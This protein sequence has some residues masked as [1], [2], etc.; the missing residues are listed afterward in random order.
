MMYFY[1]LIICIVCNRYVINRYIFIEIGR[2]F[3]FVVF[4]FVLFE[5]VKEIRMLDFLWV[6][7]LENS[8]LFY[9]ERSKVD[10][11]KLI[12]IMIL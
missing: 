10:Y 3:N 2:I 1:F 7:C 9:L 4:F 5:D 6:V 8:V 11:F 12:G